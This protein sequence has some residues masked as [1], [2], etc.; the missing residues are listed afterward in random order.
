MQVV[1]AFLYLA[2][3]D[4]SRIN[5]RYLRLY[6]EQLLGKFTVFSF[7]VQVVLFEN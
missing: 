4:Y 6:D 1:K 7:L 5:D 2:F 3:M